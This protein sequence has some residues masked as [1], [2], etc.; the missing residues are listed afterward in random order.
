MLMRDAISAGWVC[1]AESS[2]ELGQPGG[3]TEQA[4]S[5]AF[6]P[7]NH[8]IGNGEGVQDQF[9]GPLMGVVTRQ[10][11]GLVRGPRRLAAPVGRPRCRGF[12]ASSAERICRTPTD[13]SIAAM[14]FIVPPHCAHTRGYPASFGPS[15]F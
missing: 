2:A 5:R 9:V 13:R 12:V 8:R 6:R 3:R 1:Q 11:V 4:D 14:R 10:A 15:Q 7:R